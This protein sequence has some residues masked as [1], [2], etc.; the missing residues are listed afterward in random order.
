M[1]PYGSGIIEVAGRPRR[2]RSPAEAIAQGIAFATGENAPKR[3][4][5][6]Q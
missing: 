3:R 4:S 1:L 2:I 5:P 6:A